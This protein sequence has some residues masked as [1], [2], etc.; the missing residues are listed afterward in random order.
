MADIRDFGTTPE[1]E[2][3][4]LVTLA[5]GALSVRL[6]TWGARLHDVRL[7]GAPW[8]LVLGS[9]GLDGYLGPMAN[10]GAVVGPVANRIA[11][12]EAVIAG[13]NHR[14]IA[15][16]AGRTTLHGGPKG[17]HRRN[18]A[19]AEATATRAVFTLDLP[20]GDEG[21]PGNRRLV[22]DYGVTAPATLDLRLSA[23]TDR[24]TLINLA[25]HP[26]WNLDGTP[27]I[28]GHRLTVAAERHIETD[29]ALIPTGALPPVAGSRFDFR[30]GPSLGAARD[31]DLNLCLADGPR[32]LTEVARLEGAKGVALALATT[33]PGLQLHDAPRMDTAPWIG[34]SGQPYGPRAGIALEPQLW[35]DACHHRGFPPIGLEPGES[36]AQ[37]SRMMFDRIG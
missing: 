8:P 34:L 11:G 29:A 4:Q 16:E 14:L 37:H 21:F 18:W 36:R 32:P 23:T 26:Y 27:D 12:A 7:A 13:R 17:C 22:A 33:E 9:P 28:S 6:L 24:A 19:L 1:G 25:P 35:P 2:T 20:D 15:N 31:L 30:T 10:F 5:A 3:V